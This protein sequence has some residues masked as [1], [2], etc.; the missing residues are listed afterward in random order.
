VTRYMI[1]GGAGFIGSNIVDRLVREGGEVVV[2][3]DFSTGKR[4]NLSHVIDRIELI[5]AD[6]C[7][8]DAVLSAC[9][10][11]DTVFHQAAIPS[12]PRSVADPLGS[13]RAAVD[14]TLS[15]LLSAR[16]EGVK[17]VVVASSSSVYGES[18]E[19]PKREAMRLDPLSPY[20]VGK[21]TAERYAAV[22]TRVYG[23]ETVSLRYF[24]VYGPRQDPHGDYA[25]V[26]PKFISLILSGKPPTVYGDGTQSRDFTFID[27]VVEANLLAAR[28]RGAA[29]MAFNVGGGQRVTLNEV[30]AMLGK[31]LGRDIAPEYAPERPGDILHSLADISNATEVLGY[32]ARTSLREGLIRTVEFFRS[33]GD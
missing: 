7:D 4:E 11:V 19:L 14:G 23:L 30:V 3:D 22:F 32:T 10:G 13:N 17:R 27:D 33:V 20:A 21:L 15:V 18:R 28:A 1:T 16:D 9:R 8:R 6:I 31:V 29:G 2:I 26:I 24:N 12:V 25:A 5:E